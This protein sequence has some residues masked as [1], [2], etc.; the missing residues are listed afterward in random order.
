MAVS[1][2]QTN[3]EKTTMKQFFYI[4]KMNTDGGSTVAKFEKLEDAQFHIEMYRRSF[5]DFN[6]HFW[7]A[8]ASYGNS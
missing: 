1:V 6:A 4:N 7:I 2:T 3:Q 8:R 5:D